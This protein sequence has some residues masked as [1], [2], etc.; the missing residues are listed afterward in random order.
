MATGETCTVIEFK[1]DNSRAISRGRDQ[2]GRYVRELNDELK[3]ADSSIMKRLI[4]KNADFGKCKRFEGRVDCYKL[5]PS[6]NSDG[7]IR[8]QNADWRKD[9][10]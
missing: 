6:V 5:C 7:S 2:Y 8:E 3:K 9:C 10:S 4:D 1:P